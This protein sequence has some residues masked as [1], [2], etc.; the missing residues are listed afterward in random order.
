MSSKNF[1]APCYHCFVP[2]GHWCRKTCNVS[3]QDIISLQRALARFGKTLNDVN[4]YVPP[5]RRRVT[6][7]E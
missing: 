3:G 5:P 4:G 2:A 1:E 6:I 7:N